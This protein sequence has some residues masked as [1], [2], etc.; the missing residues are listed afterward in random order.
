MLKDG[1][2]GV[3]GWLSRAVMHKES[4]H[5]VILTN[6]LHICDLILQHIHHKVG[7]CGCNHVIQ[8]YWTAGVSVAIRKILSR[9]VA[10]QQL[11]PTPGCQQL[12]NLPSG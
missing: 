2:L 4:K 12:A 11:H 7:Y 3:G 8:R 10:C 6:D 1:V 5:L 9:C